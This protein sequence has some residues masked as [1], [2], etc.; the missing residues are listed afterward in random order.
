MFIGKFLHLFNNLDLGDSNRIIHSATIPDKSIEDASKC[1][2]VYCRSLYI[3]KQVIKSHS[4]SPLKSKQML[5]ISLNS[6]LE[7]FIQL[8]A[9]NQLLNSTTVGCQI[10][11]HI[12]ALFIV[13]Y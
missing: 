11:K 5:L 2:N 1:P 3:L 6:S 12:L 13:F 7:A 4:D 8:L 9:H 10:T